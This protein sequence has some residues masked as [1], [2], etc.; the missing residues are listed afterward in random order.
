MKEKK[1]GQ[2]ETE[3][4]RMKHYRNEEKGE[5]WKEWNEGEKKGREKQIGKKEREI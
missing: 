5:K 1:I 4:D 3:I 2:S